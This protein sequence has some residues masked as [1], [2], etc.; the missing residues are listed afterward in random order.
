MDSGQSRFMDADRAEPPVVRDG[1][2]HG[3]GGLQ[4]PVQPI[5]L[6]LHQG[7]RSHQDHHAYAQG[8]VVGCRGTQQAH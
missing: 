6:D 7:Q 4:P 2:L 3:G 8:A 5:R 1:S